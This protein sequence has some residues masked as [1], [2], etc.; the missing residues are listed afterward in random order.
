[1]EAQ[2]RPTRFANFRAFNWGVP[3]QKIDFTK[4]LGFDAVSEQLTDGVD[5]QNDTV[6]ATLGAKVGTEAMAIVFA[7]T[8]A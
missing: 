5:F 8:D 6:S 4:L 7:P 3:M 2:P 1:M